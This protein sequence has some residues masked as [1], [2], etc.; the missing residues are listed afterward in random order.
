LRYFESLLTR[1]AARHRDA[2][3]RCGV[4]GDPIGHSLSPALHRAGYAAA[5]LEWE[6]DAHRVSAG[7]LA[8]FVAGCGPAWR[9][10]SLTMPLKREAVEL[11]DE[12]SDVARA[13]RAANTLVFDS[14]RLYADNTDVPGAV[15]AM[16]ERSGAEIH[17][18]HI[19]GGGATAGSVLLALAEMGCRSFTLHLRH[20]GRAAET[21]AVAAGFADPLEVRTTGID[22]PATGDIVVS[23]IPAAAQTPGV[24]SSCADAPVVFDVVY[25]PWPTALASSA[26]AGGRVVVSGLDLLIHQAGL[27]FQ[28]FTGIPAPLAAMRQAAET[29]MS[30][31]YQSARHISA[32]QSPA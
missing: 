15:A 25:D 10:L 13:A 14:G 12:I 28:A 31:R 30:V 7:G 17:S 32:G 4:L 29:A 20:P 5:G 8:E 19:L 24:V 3:M 21:L 1:V 11:A 6:Y 16:R 2:T 23:T 9:G 27:Q 26:L 18:A 22:T